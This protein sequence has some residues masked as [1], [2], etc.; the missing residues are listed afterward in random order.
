MNKLERLSS[1]GPTNR[2]VECFTFDAEGIVR[3][4]KAEKRTETAVRMH[5]RRVIG[6]VEFV[7]ASTGCFKLAGQ[8][9]ADQDE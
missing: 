7:S 5:A 6:T 8:T 3:F 4:L 1:R 9:N 2:R